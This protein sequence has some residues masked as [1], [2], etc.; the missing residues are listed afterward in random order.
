MSS[1]ASIVGRPGLRSMLRPWLAPLGEMAR[2]PEG[3]FSLLLVGGLLLI[4][5]FA[6]LIAPYDAAQQDI[7][8]RLEGPSETYWL[9]TDHLGRDLFSRLVYGTRV[10]LGTAFPSV[11]G[12]LLLGLVLG[13]TAGYVG[14][15]IDNL[16]LIVMDTLQAFPAIILTLA[17]AGFTGAF[18]NERHPGDRHC[19][20]T[21]L[22]PHCARP[23]V[24]LSRNIHSL[25][26]N[27]HWA[28]AICAYVFIHIL[29]N[30]LAPLVILLAMDLPTAI[31]TEAGLSFLGLGVRATNALLGHHLGG[32]LC[33][34]PQFTLAG[35]VG[36]TDA[37][38]HHS[39]FHL[40]RRDPARRSRPQTVGHTESMMDSVAGCPR[41]GCQIPYQ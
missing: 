15:N 21:R 37:H 13:L 36:F 5:L 27:D 38:A 7:R 22:C 20:H 23:G 14:G 29:P 32:W 39:G 35:V 40:V 11:S 34:D 6:P 30:I 4:I 12:A 24:G 26:W 1:E 19:L 9:G 18:G 3:I 33:Q 28:P 25:K 16:I 31:T 41:A 2:R 10:A 17:L 8:H